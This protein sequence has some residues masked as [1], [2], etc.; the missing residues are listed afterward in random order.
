MLASG[1]NRAGRLSLGHKPEF[2]PSS[3]NTLTNGGGPYRGLMSAS[4]VCPPT[5]V[6][7]DTQRA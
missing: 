5:A 1:H 4:T 2:P 6:F 3:E 7:G